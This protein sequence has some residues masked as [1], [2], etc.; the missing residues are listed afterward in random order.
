MM[1]SAGRNGDG[2]TDPTGK[3]DG[4]SDNGGLWMS[5]T[6]KEGSNSRA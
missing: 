1:M 3:I 4:D 6:R 2:G 5:K